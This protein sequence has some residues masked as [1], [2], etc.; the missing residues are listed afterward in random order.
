[1][2]LLPAKCPEC[3]GLVEVDNEKRAGICLHCG[4]P[5]VVEDAIKTFNICYNVSG[6]FTANHNYSEGA[7]VNIYEDKSKDF[8]ITAGVLKKYKGASVDVVIPDGVFEIA[9]ECFSNLKIKSVIIP[10]GVT[11][12]GDYA[13]SGCKQLTSVIVPDSVTSIGVGAF[14]DS[15]GIENIKFPD[16]FKFKDGFV[17]CD[18]LKLA[19]TK[20][21]AGLLKA[22]DFIIERQ[23]ASTTLLQ[24]WLKMGYRI[25]S[26]MIDTIERMGIIGPFRELKPREV[27]VSKEQWEQVRDNYI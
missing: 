6:D 22:I 4:N 19:P 20:L 13:F 16:M 14:N 5:F 23:A 1:M 24:R 27:L 17:Y 2:A 10:D 7:V 8:V 9:D 18:F 26:E 3:G 25:A 15:P 11:S 12:I 21:D